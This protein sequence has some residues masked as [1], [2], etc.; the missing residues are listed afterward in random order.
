[1][2]ASALLTKLVP[3]SEFPGQDNEPSE[4]YISYVLR[5][6]NL[7]PPV[8]WNNWW[9]ELHW[10]RFTLMIIMPLYTFIAAYYTPLQRETAVWMVAFYF[11]S[12]MG[13]T[14]GHHRLW[15]HRSYNASATLEYILAFL[16]AA[17]VMGPIIW[18]A[19]GHRAHHRYT[20]TDLDPYNARRGLFWTHIGWVIFKPRCKHGI[21]DIS[22][23]KNNHVVMWQLRQYPWLVLVAAV[24]FPTAVAGL[25][26][27]DW[28]GG[29]VY[30]ALLRL[31]IVHQTASC[32][33]S[34]AHWI[35]HT[36]F[37]DKHSPR[38]H[39]LTALITL[40]EGYH[41][42][43]HQF[44]MD[45]RNAIRWYQYD[46]TKWLIWLCQKVGLASHLK[47]FS[48]NEIRKGELTME[49]RQLRKKQDE[50]NWPSQNN[51]LPVVSW[52]SYQSQAQSRS[53][54]CIA[55]F[56]HDVEDFLGEHPG[57]R[58]LLVKHIGKDATAAFF[59]G[60]YDHSHAA[61]NLLA[62]KRVGILQG[63][64]P[65]CSEEK[66]IPPSQLLRVAHMNE[67]G[68]SSH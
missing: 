60:I 41:N 43:H 29:F 61:H 12:G 49:L 65:H 1:M 20:D 11:L 6:E 14:A 26:W 13:I 33:N 64:V 25:G 51:D 19:R 36:P 55:G 22:D 15:A 40:G 28:K 59:G 68:I 56:I 37:D 63:G 31:V 7:R 45:Y 58:R 5:H 16:A 47:T 54:I 27:G 44:P 46:P 66:V 30:A 21:V 18:W 39:L 67:L 9:R 52:A 4:S 2:V 50:L 53:L 24:V 8:A 35:G 38:D 34:L 48:D 17:S 23:L 42:F 10:G 62:M 57:G 32:V 3:P